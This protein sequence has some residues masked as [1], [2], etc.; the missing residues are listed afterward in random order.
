MKQLLLKRTLS[1]NIRYKSHSDKT[2]VAS[3]LI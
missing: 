2:K 1:I 3:E